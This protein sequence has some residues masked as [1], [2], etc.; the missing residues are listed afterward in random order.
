M[1]RSWYFHH[2][3]CGKQE[4]LSSPRFRESIQTHRQIL[5]PGSNIYP[6]TTSKP[7][8]WR[9]ELWGLGKAWTS[10][11]LGFHK[12]TLSVVHVLKHNKLLLLV[13]NSLSMWLGSTIVNIQ[14]NF[15]GR[16]P[17]ILWMKSKFFLKMDSSRCAVTKPG[18]EIAWLVPWSAHPHASTSGHTTFH[19]QSSLRFQSANRCACRCHHSTTSIPLIVFII[20]ISPFFS[21][22][23]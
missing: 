1:T 19:I 3:C 5:S 4:F 15:L 18:L 22:F 2:G 16:L 7:I 11:V 21:L 6:N 23:P 13:L 8:P 20:F 9:G 10:A 17:H 12:E 14:T